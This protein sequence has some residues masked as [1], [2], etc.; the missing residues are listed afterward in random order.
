MPGDANRTTPGYI[1]L[2]LQNTGV[3]QELLQVFEEENKSQLM[4]TQN[5]FVFHKS[6]LRYRKQ[7]SNVFK[8]LKEKD[9]QC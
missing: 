6:R 3:K 1:T 4:K 2:K 8:I 9:F 7:W 5:D